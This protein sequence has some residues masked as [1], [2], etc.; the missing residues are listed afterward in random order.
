MSDQQP[1]DIQKRWGEAVSSGTLDA[2][3]QFFAQLRSAFP[4]LTITADPGVKRP[5]GYGR[6]QLTWPLSARAQPSNAFAGAG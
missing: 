2:L 5:N 4:D 3:D 1:M 6:S